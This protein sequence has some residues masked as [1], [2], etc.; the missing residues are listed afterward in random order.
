MHLQESMECLS[1]KIKDGGVRGLL[2]TDP[3]EAPN[4]G[5]RSNLNEEL[6]TKP[7]GG[8]RGVVNSVTKN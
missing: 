3:T 4:G 5:A 6:Y 2:K 8:L 7:P 1:T